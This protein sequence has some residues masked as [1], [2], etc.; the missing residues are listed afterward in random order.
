MMD[1]GAFFLT[2]A[3]YDTSVKKGLQKPTIN[4][5]C[6]LTRS[7]NDERLH[8]H[9]QADADRTRLDA[10]HLVGGRLHNRTLD[11]L[12]VVAH[13]LDE[14]GQVPLAVAQARAGVESAVRRTMEV[15]IVL[16]VGQQRV[17]A[18]AGA[19]PVRAGAPGIFAPLTAPRMPASWPSLSDSVACV[20]PAARSNTRL[21]V[22]LALISASAP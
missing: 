5:D 7:A 8:L 19:G 6:G 18:V 12:L 3:D 15:R 11:H 4:S 16:A 21:D 14:D 13:V 2:R 1:S 10:I 22:G 9:A 20:T 17:A